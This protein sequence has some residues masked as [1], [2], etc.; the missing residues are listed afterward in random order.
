M[1]TAAVLT[2]A[3]RRG[4]EFEGGPL[5]VLAGPGTGKTRVIVERVAHMVRGRGID[6][7]RIVSITFTIKA[8][9]EM[10]RRLAL[11]LGDNKADL[12]RAC[13]SHALGRELVL[14]FSD[15]LGFGGPPQLIDGPVTRRTLRELSRELGSFAD[16]PSQ[17]R[18]GAV[19]E[20]AK[21]VAACRNG[22]VTAPRALEHAAR[23][24]RDVEAR[25]E[26]G[27]ETDDEFLAD[28]GRQRRFADQA[29]LYDAFEK[30]CH[31]RGWIT[32]DELIT[33][34][35]R[36]LRDHATPA[37]MIRQEIQAVLFD[38]FQD[39]NLAQIE[40]LR[41]LCPPE[42]SPDLCVVGDDDQSIY[43]F[44][45]ADDRGFE[46]F[47][48]IW[49]TRVETVRLEE[50]HRSRDPIV[51]LAG[52]IMDGSPHRFDPCKVLKVAA[53]KP[54]HLTGPMI[55][56][57]RVPRDRWKQDAELV[58][59][60][61]LEDRRRAEARGEAPTM[62]SKIAVITRSGKDAARIQAALQ[63]ERIPSRLLV[64]TRLLDDPGV[65]DVMQWVTLLTVPAAWWAVSQV[66]VRPPI[67][68]PGGAVVALRRRYEES[69]GRL[70]LD[71]AGA[72]GMLHSV[73]PMVAW[74][75]EHSAEEAGAGQF[76]KLFDRL[77][78][79]AAG[80][81]A[82]R[83]VLEIIAAVGTPDTELL[84]ASERA[85]RVRSLAGFMTYV[86]SRL[87]MMEAPGDLGA[88]RQYLDDVEDG[89]EGVSPDEQVSGA[90]EGGVQRGGEEDGE[91]VQLLTAHKSKGLEF[92][93]VYVPR[94]GEN[95]YTASAR[96]EESL[97]PDGLLERHGLE[98]LSEVVRGSAEARRVFYVA[99]TR[100][101]RRLVLIAPTPK[102]PMTASTAV[103]QK[104]ILLAMSGA[105]KDRVVLRQPDEVMNSAREAGVTLAAAG[106]IEAVLADLPRRQTRRLLLDQARRAARELAAAALERADDALLP[107]EKRGDI[108]RMLG[109][110]S[111]MLQAAAIVEA[112]QEMPE[113]VHSAGENVR[114]FAL[115]LAELAKE[116]PKDADFEGALIHAP[117]PPLRLS[118]THITDY[119]RCPRCY[120][121]KHVLGFPEAQ[122][123]EVSLGS[124]AHQALEKFYKLWRDA[125]AAGAALPGKADLLRLGKE[126]YQRS[127]MP[128]IAADRRVMEDLLTLLGRVM[129]TLHDPE[130]HI[131]ELEKY[132][133]FAFE[134]DGQRHTLSAKIDRVD[135]R[136]DGGY[137]IIDYKTGG[138]DKQTGRAQEKYA[139][140]KK[141]DLQMGIYA[142]ALPHVFAGADAG[143]IPAGEAQYWVLG[144]GVRGTIDFSA[145]KL[146]KVRQQVACAIEGILQ[147]RFAPKEDCGGM[148]GRLGLGVTRV[149]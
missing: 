70:E 122:T 47:R 69:V 55:E 141:D 66:M 85:A 128:G 60:L 87:G 7:A 50:N 146:E 46:R 77:S 106:G 99:C 83:A 91:A 68:M 82:D 18:D 52:V 147:G 143:V 105:L 17:G 12:V 127:V 22:N 130:A 16:L 59:A 76:L 62:L 88:L 145:M 15:V 65:Q 31:E 2:A 13:T 124:V 30:R 8:A 101:E 98:Q 129:D 135:Q 32:M 36:L 133:E 26:A 64:R 43:R 29:A 10:R 71:R 75:R 110:S 92:D 51:R 20:T 5:I 96:S 90:A 117:T 28:A 140:P 54:E 57:V 102:D 67:G 58:A 24:A 11:E 121:I 34:P 108:A 23:W 100:A 137:R 116:A 138:I 104:E 4:V 112:N 37:A 114:R 1:K 103:F 19:G 94:V 132:V 40:L 74:M 78:E 21:F 95:G 123:L 86:Q 42:R 63:L 148:C 25:R 126:C 109:E 84:P 89:D 125:D 144:A 35:I 131:I 45:G 120:Y 41:L 136:R 142:M 119:D 80:V 134:H 39:A 38:E 115:R 149:G 33:L 73:A 97:L 113:W 118:H 79:F 3:Q 6:P 139:A 81:A 107:D 111:R 49:G 9:E 53:S 72:G 56:L 27:S 93:T 14:R 44:R 61:I 48:K